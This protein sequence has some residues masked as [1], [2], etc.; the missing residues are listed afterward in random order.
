MHAKLS[1]DRQVRSKRGEHV[2]PGKVTCAYKRNKYFTNVSKDYF[3]YFKNPTQ[4]LEN[5][6]HLNGCAH[7]L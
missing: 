3:K 1:K 7:C 5:S 6:R 4:L 2:A